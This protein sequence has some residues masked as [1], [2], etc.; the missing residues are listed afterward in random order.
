M[1]MVAVAIFP[2]QISGGFQGMWPWK[3]SLTVAAFGDRVPLL[4]D[5]TIKEAGSCTPQYRYPMPARR[6]RGQGR[7]EGQGGHGMERGK[8]VN[9]LWV[10]SHVG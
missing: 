6:R 1:H 2:Y 5:V 4:Q 9:P 7:R 8:R 10:Y 3:V